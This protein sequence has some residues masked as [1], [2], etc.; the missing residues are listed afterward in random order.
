[1]V[2]QYM[3]TVVLTGLSF[4]SK[5]NS[6]NCDCVR[7]RRL[8]IVKNGS[9]TAYTRPLGRH[10]LHLSRKLISRDLG[11]HGRLQIHLTHEVDSASGTGT[12]FLRP[13]KDGPVASLGNH[14]VRGCCVHG[15]LA[16][17]R[18]ESIAAVRNLRPRS[19]A[20]AVEQH[21]SRTPPRTLHTAIGTCAQPVQRRSGS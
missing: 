3:Y 14:A 18:P 9:F 20:A 16:H 12:S 17:R 7:T 1:M 2:Q 8:Y 5:A 13:G 6:R 11:D 21:V 15:E 10:I 19:R 4:Q